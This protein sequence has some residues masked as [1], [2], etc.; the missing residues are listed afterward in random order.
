[1]SKE[2]S[3]NRTYWL[4]IVVLTLI[5]M[6]LAGYLTYVHVSVY[7][8]PAFKSSCNINQSFNCETVA[9]SSYAIIAGL[10]TSV[11]GLIGYL[12]LLIVGLLGWNRSSTG[13][14]PL[15]GM[16]VVLTFCCMVAGVFFA[17]ISYTQINSLCIYCMGTYFINILLFLLMF[18]ALSKDG[19]SL[20]EGFS[21]FL[22]WLPR[23]LVYLIVLGIILFVGIRAYPPYWQAKWKGASLPIKVC[24]GM[25]QDSAMDHGEDENGHWIGA[26]NP[27]IT[28]VEFADYECP[29]CKRAHFDLRLLLRKC[30]EGIRL[31][32]R[33]YPLD[34]KCNPRINRPFHKKACVLARA[35]HCAGLQGKFWGAN[36]FLYTKGKKLAKKDLVANMAKLGLNGD[37]LHA[38]ITGKPARAAIDNDMAAG[39]GHKMRGTPFFVMNGV[40]F[41][42]G[43][44]P[45]EDIIKALNTPKVV[46]QRPAPASRPK[47]QKASNPTPR[48]RAKAAPATSRTPAPPAPRR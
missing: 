41:R 3:N 6:G 11:W 48:R 43:Y 18:P 44:I 16:L 21:A 42:K 40:A 22:A 2:A 29:Y 5:G 13:S 20:G 26:K 15:H 8:N 47:V 37:K 45:K 12:L 4:V 9:L 27:H 17:Y 14:S 35:A 32:H 25:R 46:A 39:R 24:G 38:C 33:H 30:P 10:P 34:H 28:I 31:Y 19:V 36:D 23:N 7:T 1:M